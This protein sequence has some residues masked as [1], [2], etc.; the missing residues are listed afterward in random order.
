MADKKDVV[1]PMHTDDIALFSIT[2]TNVA[3]DKISWVKK[4]PVYQNEE[5]NNSIH[6]NISGDGSQYIDLA[7]STL[8]VKLKIE[9]SEGNLFIQGKTGESPHVTE[10]YA[11]PVDNVL[12]SLW[13]HVDVKLNNS[14]VSFSTNNYMYKALFENLLFYSHNARDY[15]MRSAGFFGESGNFDASSPVEVPWNVGLNERYQLWKGQTNIHTQ[16]VDGGMKDPSMVEFE[17]PLLAD[18]FNQPKYILN[19]VDIDIFLQPKNDAFRLMT[20]PGGTVAKIKIQEIYLNVCKVD[21]D[22]AARIGIEKGLKDHKS[23]AQYP[24]QRTDI[25]TYNIP[26]GSFGDSIEDLYQGHVPS[27]IIVGLVNSS[28]FSGNFTKN[29]FYF[30]HFDLNRI[31]FYVDNVSTPEQPLTVDMT[32]SNYLRGY[33]SLYKVAGKLNDDTDI[34]IT[35]TSYREGY[36]LFGFNVDPTASYD[37]S[38]LGKSKTG[39]TKLDLNFKNALPHNITVVVYAVFPEVMEIDFERVVRLKSKDSRHYA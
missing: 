6:F 29:P 37:M 5:G 36:N 39:I 20:F 28:A 15:Q 4:G 14:M 2:P 31:A 26:Q 34:G 16:S 23:L 18:I 21:I 9:D 19:M 10:K 32:E 11:I 35:R 33:L 7:H 3:V 8:Y 12:H 17:G 22:P 25:R 27:K 30:Q 24:F 38:N 1:V 13:D